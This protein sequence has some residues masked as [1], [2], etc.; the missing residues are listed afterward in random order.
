M[1]HSSQTWKGHKSL[2][3]KPTYMRKSH[4]GQRLWSDYT[5]SVLMECLHWTTHN[6]QYAEVR[7]LQA[8]NKAKKQLLHFD[9]IFFIFT[10][11]CKNWTLIILTLYD[12]VQPINIAYYSHSLHSC[13]VIYGLFVHTV[14][15]RR[16]KLQLHIAFT[17]PVLKRGH[18]LSTDGITNSLTLYVIIRSRPGYCVYTRH[19]GK[20]VHEQK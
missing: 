12:E 5:A 10:T 14:D 4:T 19:L 8:Q 13:I 2:T 17:S 3:W 16:A 18:L 9:I 1:S 7:K 6:Y 20:N 15:C 11:F